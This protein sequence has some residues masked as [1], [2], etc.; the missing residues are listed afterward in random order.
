MIISGCLVHSHQMFQSG[1][2]ESTTN[3]IIITDFNV[4]TV[5][6]FVTC[7]YTCQCVA[8]LE[9][10]VEL[11]KIGDKYAAVSMRICSEKLKQNTCE[12]NCMNLLSIVYS[13]CLLLIILSY[14]VCV[15]MYW[16]VNVYLILIFN[17]NRK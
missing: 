10:T 2:K 7:M 5:K 14:V 11:Y 13:C 15:C 12:E 1:M 3:E 17:N 9:E 16:Y 8:T 4:D 6:A